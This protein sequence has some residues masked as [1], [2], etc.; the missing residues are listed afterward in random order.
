MAA[1]KTHKFKLI[2][3]PKGLIKE[4]ITANPDAMETWVIMRA[5]S[6]LT[7]NG[8]VGPILPYAEALKVVKELDPSYPV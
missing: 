2:S 1:K 4:A 3:K 6:L 5:Q 7:K 8:T